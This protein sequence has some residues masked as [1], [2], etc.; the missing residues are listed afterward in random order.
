MKKKTN[1]D[2][3]TNRAYKLY[4]DKIKYPESYIYPPILHALQYAYRL[5]RHSANQDI[6]K[7]LS[8][9][10]YRTDLN[11]VNDFKGKD[12]YFGNIKQSKSNHR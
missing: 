11:S 5:G 3:L 12:I 2:R 1:Q 9:L 4:E 7:K 10:T 8:D 6:I